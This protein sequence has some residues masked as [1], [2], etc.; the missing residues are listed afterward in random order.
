MNN[1]E[2][3]D[4]VL[5]VIRNDMIGLFD[6]LGDDLD[7]TNLVERLVQQAPRLREMESRYTQ[8][9]IFADSLPR[10][11]EYMKDLEAATEPKDRLIAAWIQFCGV[12]A[13]PT[14]PR[15][16]ALMAPIFHV[17]IICSYLPKEDAGGSN[18]TAPG[19]KP[20]EDPQTL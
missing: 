7:E 16:A 12:A 5:D 13:D 8:L 10:R 18:E 6:S 3:A 15:M 11:E 1:V 19:E 14:I 9:R 2:T 4:D 17:P 20:S